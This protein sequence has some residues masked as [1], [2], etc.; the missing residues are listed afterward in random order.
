MPFYCVRSYFAIKRI[1]AGAQI[2]IKKNKVLQMIN[3]TAKIQKK[4][5]GILRVQSK[6]EIT[7]MTETAEKKYVENISRQYMPKD[8]HQ[9]KIEHLHSLDR[10]VR[11]PAEIFSWIFGAAGTLVL[12]AGMCLAMKVIG[13][14][15]PLGIV[16][17]VVGIAMVSVN[18]LIYKAILKSRKKKYA[19]Q[20]VQLSNEI[21]N[22]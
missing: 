6:K 7:I 20:V 21:L 5:R 18:Y 11:R 19:E 8:E 3:K 10:K 12:G 1:A 14:L 22:N 17:G 15:M 9:T 4:H 13:N 2:F 16:V